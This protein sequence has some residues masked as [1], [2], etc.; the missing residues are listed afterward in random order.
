MIHFYSY[1]VKDEHGDMNRDRYQDR[2]QG[3]GS[4]DKDSCWG[5]RQSRGG[6]GAVMGMGILWLP[7]TRPL[8]VTLGHRQR[9]ELW[10]LAFSWHSC[11]GAIQKF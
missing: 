1:N 2:E 11:S 9:Q 10:A 7:L 5:Q 4:R 3:A 8:P 6:T